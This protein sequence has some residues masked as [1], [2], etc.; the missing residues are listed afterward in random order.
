MTSIGPQAYTS[1]Y[2]GGYGLAPTSAEAR[3]AAEE[4]AAEQGGAGA[5]GRAVNVTL[6]DAAKAAMSLAN[7]P[8]DGVVSAARG[9]IDK[10]L[11]AAKASEA[12]TGEK[13][14]IDLGGL[15][16]RSLFAVASNQGGGFT[17]GEQ[18]LAAATLSAKFESAL[19]GPLAASRITGDNAAVY[20]AALAYLDKAGPE[21]KAS[22]DW[23]AQREAVVKGLQQ[24]A[25]KPGVL[26][27]GVENDPVA[28]YIEKLDDAAPSPATRDILKVAGDVRTVLDAAYAKDPDAAP[29]LSAFDDRALA[30]VALNKGEQ[31]SDEEVFAARA[32]IRDRAAGNISAGYGS[33]AEAN[34]SGSLGANLIARYAGMSEEERQAQGWTPELYAQLLE[35]HKLSQKL[36]D[37]AGGAGSYFGG[38]RS[39]SLLDYLT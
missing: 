39:S 33:I 27:S 22:P 28:E 18:K 13:P 8:I 5:G 36:A 30:A 20:K 31:F 11:A 6:S 3:K 23:A 14:N 16:R 7:D 15:D 4:R 21:E 9:V 12:I 26:P 32:E 17:A 29:N 25:A 19:A 24:L 34:A 10:L 1:N 2:A 38:G 35:S 37:M